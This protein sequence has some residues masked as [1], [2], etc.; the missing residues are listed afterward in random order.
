MKSNKVVFLTGD[1]I[2]VFYITKS[3][4]K[5]INGKAERIVQSMHFSFDQWA[6]A[7]APR[8]VSMREFFSADEPNCLNCP[9][10]FNSGNSKCYT[11][12]YMQFS[13][14]MSQLRSIPPE[15][16]TPL[17][18]LKRDA[19]LTM[20]KGRYMR[21][22]AYGEPVY[23]PLGLVRDIVNNASSWTGYTHQWSNPNFNGY[24]LYFMASVHNVKEAFEASTFGYRSFISA[25]KDELADVNAVQCP[26]SK[27]ANYKSSCDI[28][29]LCSGIQGKGAK[30]V[31]INTH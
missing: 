29:Q 31:K 3:T 22:G 11:H 15:A 30:D 21:F 6:L 23:T 17:N 27:E 16:L 9:Y 1:V 13:G 5:K 26:A 8:K 28:C 2:N 20:V 4:N 24:H 18:A 7:N 12:K 14:M 19:L 25:I 10:S